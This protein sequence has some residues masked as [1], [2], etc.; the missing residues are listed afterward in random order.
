MS[1]STIPGHVP[2]ASEGDAGDF[3]TTIPEAF[4]GKPYL[5]GVGDMESL[6]VKFDGAQ[7]LIGKRVGLPEEGAKPEAWDAYYKDQ[8]RPDTPEGYGIH[9]PDS[10]GE[11]ATFD[12]GVQEMFHKAGVSMRQ[13]EQL[14]NGYEALMLKANEA[15][16]EG[17]GIKDQEFDSMLDQQ[18]GAKQ[19]EVLAVGKKLLDENV[20]ESLKPLL[21]GLDN[22]ALMILAGV[23]DGVNTKYIREDAAGALR[24][25]QISS[26]QTIADLRAEGVRLMGSKEYRDSTHP[27]HGAVTGKIGEVY[28]KIGKLQP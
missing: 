26:G 1:E 7:T 11:V 24:G 21:A 18:F 5:E 19:D 27:G 6:M 8:G 23:L 25:A 10:E 2:A 20:P 16:G 9:A 15:V 22:K 14:Q 12:K 3:M 4:R 17:Q 28:A 13:A